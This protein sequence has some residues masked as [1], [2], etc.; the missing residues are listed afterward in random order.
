LE[1]VYVSG[2]NLG[3][4]AIEVDGT[5]LRTVI[6]ANDRTLYNQRT[7]INYLTDEI[8]T[9][10]VYAQSGGVIGVDAFLTSETTH[11]STAESPDGTG[12]I[13]GTACNPSALVERV[14][15]N[16]NGTQSFGYSSIMDFTGNGRYVL[17]L[18]STT[19][20]PEDTNARDD[21]Y[22]AD[23]QLCTITLVVAT[24]NGVAGYIGGS[25]PDITEDGRWVL[26]HSASTNLIANDTNNATDVFLRDR[27]NNTTIRLSVSS[28]GAQGNS[29]SYAMQISENGLIA[30]FQSSASNLS[31]GDSANSTDWFIRDLSTNTTTM[32]PRGI[33]NMSTDGRYFSLLTTAALVAD[34]TNGIADAYLWDRQTNTYIWASRGPNPIQGGTN[35]STVKLTADAHYLLFYSARNNL[36]S[37]DADPASNFFRYNRLTNTLEIMP[38]ATGRTQF[39]SA[40]GEFKISSN[41][42][43]VAFMYR[44]SMPPYL[45]FQ[46]NAQIY[47]QDLE[48]GQTNRVSTNEQGHVGDFDSSTYGAFVSDDGRFV[49]FDSRANNLI[50]GD[51]FDY[52]LD[53]YLFDRQFPV[54]P[55][56]LTVKSNAA[57]SI[58]L[59]WFYEQSNISAFHIERSLDGLNGWMEI[60]TVDSTTRTY[61][62]TTVSAGNYYY[63]RLRM[64]R[65]DTL[66]FSNYSN[67]AYATIGSCTIGA[68]IQRVS[69]ATDGSQSLNDSLATGSSSVDITPDGL[70]IVFDSAAENLVPGD[71]NGRRDV[72]LREATTCDIRLVSRNTNGDQGNEDSTFPTIS[73]LGHYIA[74]Q[75]DATNLDS[76]DTNGFTDIF[77]YNTIKQQTTLSS[78][79]SNS[80][81][82]ILTLGNGPSVHPD[83]SAESSMYGTWIGFESTTSSWNESYGSYDT[84]GVVDVFAASVES[85]GLYP[86]SNNLYQATANGPSTHPRVFLNFYI[87]SVMYTSE[88]SNLVNYDANNAAD[89]YYYSGGAGYTSMISVNRDSTGWPGPSINAEGYSSYPI[90]FESNVATL[91]PNDTNGIT[92]VFFY[93]PYSDPLQLVRVSVGINGEEANGPSTQPMMSTDRRFVAFLSE[94]SN[95]VPNDTNGVQ[96]L[97]LYDRQIGVTRRVS[98]SATGEQANGPTLTFSM[99]TNGRYI[100]FESTA[101]NLVPN[102]TNGTRDIFLFDRDGDGTTPVPDYTPTPT[103]TMTPTFTRTPTPSRTPTATS[104]YTP[105]STPTS[106]A[107]ATPS[108]IALIAPTNFVTTAQSRTA[109]TL[110]WSDSNTT[111]TEYRVERS[112][113]GSTGFQ[114]IAVIPVATTYSFTDTGLTPSTDYYYRARAYRGSDGEFSD[115]SQIRGAATY[116]ACAPNALVQRVAI[117]SNGRPISADYADMTGDG[118]YIVFNTLTQASPEDTNSTWDVYIHD[119]LTCQT[120]LVSR[121]NNGQVGNSSS[122]KS[123]ISD[124]GRWI[125]FMSEATNFA[126]GTSNTI[127]QIY[128]HDQQT[129]QTTLTSHTSTGTPG[130]SS[131]FNPRISSDGR[132]I[133]F[134]SNAANLVPNDAV[135]SVSDIYVYDHQTNQITRVSV[136][137]NGNPGNDSSGYPTI[138]DDG[139][140]I[141]FE[142]YSTNLTSINIARHRNIFVHDRQTGQTSLVSTRIDG[143][144]TLLDSQNAMISGNG[145]YV[146]FSAYDHLSSDPLEPQGQIYLRDIQ[147]GAF[148]LISRAPDGSF[149]DRYSDYPVITPDGRFVF[150][151]TAATNLGDDGPDHISNVYDNYIYDRQTQSSYNANRDYQGNISS[152]GSGAAKGAISDDGSITLWYA[153]GVLPNSSWSYFI[154]NRN[155]LPAP[156]PTSTPTATVTPS[157]SSTLTN[158]PTSTPTATATV[159]PSPTNTPSATNTATLTPTAIPSD[160]PSSTPTDTPTATATAS[161]S[162]TNT[163]T[164]T[165]TWTHTPSI[166]PSST[167]T[168]SF[169][170]TRTPSNTPSATW[171]SSP[172]P[173]ATRMAAPQNFDTLAI[174]DL[175]NPALYLLDTLD[176]QPTATHIHPVAV[177]TSAGVTGVMGDWN[178]DGQKTPGYHVGSTGIFYTTNT[179]NPT[180]SADWVATWF[181]MFNRPAIAG[182]FAGSTHD[183]IGVVDSGNFPPYGTAFALYF[184]CNL[185]GG[186]PAKSFQWLSI[187]LPDEQGY[188]GMHQFE[189]GDFDSDGFDSVAI[190]RGAFIAYT[191]ITPGIGDAAFNLAQYWGTPETSSEGDFVVGDWDGNGKDSFGI[192]Y[193]H[194]FYR[195]DDLQW[196]SGVYINQTLPTLNAIFVSVSSWRVR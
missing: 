110:T 103:F 158:T 12:G 91:V 101:S 86:I 94:A 147:T 180:S 167:V 57:S 168:A 148:E 160:T 107:T 22:V 153:Y 134:E 53:S 176:S 174:F 118:R 2:P 138:S 21:L 128:L 27:Q 169:T 9:L 144:P 181:G 152:I 120:N 109:I 33:V 47:V 59:A 51:T 115:Y 81:G 8:H 4:L 88:A 126:M 102:D 79:Q 104:T 7:T 145:R 54:P 84:N 192:Y 137:S 61:T 190:R 78:V 93:N 164:Y 35:I 130:D 45:P 141:A 140:Y 5:V 6:T 34:D 37:N 36:V 161:P 155:Y 71:T 129:G 75:S 172:L 40:S 96:D 83:L 177:T 52:Y 123:S 46:N 108:P 64:Q 131:S 193:T 90:V 26:F 68:I 135:P 119:R 87:P 19:L 32:L 185:T 151:I 69:V 143:T 182:R 16:S 15:T 3:T 170:P 29:D 159:T 189:A 149:A 63:Y 65:A 156:T 55:S 73:S 77:V 95:L 114:E 142:S 196:N 85:H 150:Y 56:Y 31:A 191:N 30:L 171:T 186:N 100:V 194:T 162:A 66:Q 50:A 175:Q 89:I 179:L 111:E 132:F 105:S 113:D 106:T 14:S 48:T 62:D 20:S 72:F 11:V 42:R 49:G 184:T 80:N 41:G 13:Q 28:S 165:A 124:D 117:D 82:N 163:P 97:F 25:V 58:D 136:D 99:S 70:Y 98:V 92:D 125:T 60:A 76:G 43:Y 116:P 23:R 10:R 17:I 133:A 187:I 166:T 173:T 39:G 112:L 122:Y 24:N 146:V 38:L 183:C 127:Y 154:F 139:R 74:Y 157:P 195:R 18:D 44:P 178:G 121:N 67:V 1:V 188:S